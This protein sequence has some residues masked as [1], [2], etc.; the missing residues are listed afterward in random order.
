MAKAKEKPQAVIVKV[1]IRWNIPDSLV[2]R[3]ASNMVV[4]RIEDAY[5]ISFFE[6]F[7]GIRLGPEE[8]VPSEVTAN[9]VA[10]VVIT[11]DKLQSV[12]KALQTHLDT[13]LEEKKRAT[14]KP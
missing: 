4:Q 3:F 7:P 12:V 14:R 11:A 5:K 13:Y 10:S 9:C 1:P 8:K 2:T 6:T